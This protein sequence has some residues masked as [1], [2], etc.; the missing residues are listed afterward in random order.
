MLWTQP[1]QGKPIWNDFENQN[2]KE[3]PPH[4]EKSFS[5]SV[6][7]PSDDRESQ[8]ST[9]LSK[10]LGAVDAEVRRRLAA[11]AGCCFV[12]GVVRL[13]FRI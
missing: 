11:I 10:L 8:Q 6:R 3:D 7:M 5:D 12:D 9:L 4:V 2:Q 1:E 13:R